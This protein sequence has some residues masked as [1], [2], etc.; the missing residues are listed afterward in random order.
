M[1]RQPMDTFCLS[2]MIEEPISP[3][4]VRATET[5]ALTNHD[6]AG[7]QLFESGLAW[8]SLTQGGLHP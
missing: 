4:V 6:F 1:C 7:L 5:P 3:T 8:A 2:I